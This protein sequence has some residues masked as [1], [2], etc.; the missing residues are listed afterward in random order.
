MGK[1][2]QAASQDHVDATAAKIRS[3]TEAI[4]VDTEAI[5]A[6]WRDVLSPELEFRVGERLSAGLSTQQL[7][8][9]EQILDSGDSDGPGRWLM[10]TVP[11]YRAIV[12]EELASLVTTAAMWFIGN[13]RNQNKEAMN[14]KG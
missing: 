5:R 14:D 4:T 6:A 12:N 8:E 1:G 11:N 9:F 13:A 10:A 7:E 3:I 2:N